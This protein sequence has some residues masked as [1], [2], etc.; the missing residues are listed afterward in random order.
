[1]S[2]LREE[3]LYGIGL[4]DQCYLPIELTVEPI[5]KEVNTTSL[6]DFYNIEIP[7]AN[8]IPNH[9]IP[10]VE[11]VPHLIA[12]EEVIIVDYYDQAIEPVNLPELTEIEY[13][14]QETEE[15]EFVWPEDIDWGAL[16][17]QLAQAL[18]EYKQENII[19]VIDTEEELL[20][21][22]NEQ[23]LPDQ[24]TEIVQTLF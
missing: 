1:M 24:D 21:P 20:F 11:L 16:L 10:V 18:T 17:P 4:S 5:E 6:E 15:I 13:E 3:C 23:V 22:N 2:N 9:A 7:I 12:D 14:E 19:E 8:E